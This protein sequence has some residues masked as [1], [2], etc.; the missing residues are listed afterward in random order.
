MLSESILL[1]PSVLLPVSWLHSETDLFQSVTKMATYGYIN[2]RFI[3][4]QFIRSGWTKKATLLIIPATL[5]GMTL[6]GL[7]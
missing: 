2:S 1:P 5:P 3:S 6:I 4:F 7:I